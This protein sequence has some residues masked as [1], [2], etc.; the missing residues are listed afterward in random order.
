MLDTARESITTARSALHSSEQF[1][2]NRFEECS[3][4]RC[5]EG[6]AVPPN[7]HVD[8]V[9]HNQRLLLLAW[10]LQPLASKA[11]ISDSAMYKVGASPDDAVGLHVMYR[12]LLH[13][14]SSV[15]VAA[16]TDSPHRED[17]IA[18]LE[19]LLSRSTLLQVLSSAPRSFLVHCS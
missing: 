9:V 12:G 1:R 15:C 7:M 11:A 10:L 13:S 2:L 6:C 8:I 4:W 16:E 14:I 19:R 3:E 5:V 18:G 17:G